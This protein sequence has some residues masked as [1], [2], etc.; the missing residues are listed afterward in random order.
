[1]NLSLETRNALTLCLFVALAGA[2]SAAQTRTVHDVL[3]GVHAVCESTD[4]AVHLLLTKTD[5]D[6]GAVDAGA[7]Q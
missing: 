6:A 1:M 2:C 7:E 3:E 5:V 4:P